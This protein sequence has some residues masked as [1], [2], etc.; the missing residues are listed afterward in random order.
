MLFQ[1]IP[2]SIVIVNFLLRQ[3]SSSL[4]VKNYDMHS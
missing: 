1:I 3:S 4:I 2:M